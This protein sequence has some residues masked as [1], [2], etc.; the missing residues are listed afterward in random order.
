MGFGRRKK[1]LADGSINDAEIAKQFLVIR[2]LIK[3]NSE[4]ANK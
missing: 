1:E 3:Q 2:N 4:A